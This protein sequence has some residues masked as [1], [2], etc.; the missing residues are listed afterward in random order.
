MKPL[1]LS[2]LQNRNVF[3]MFARKTFHKSFDVESVKQPLLLLFATRWCKELLVRVEQA[4]ET[5]HERSAD[6]VGMEGSITR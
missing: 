2:L 4:G 6:L 5:S 3:S 1:T